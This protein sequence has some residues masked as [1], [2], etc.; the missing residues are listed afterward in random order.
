MN[1]YEVTFKDNSKKTIRA[2]NF[3]L[4]GSDAFVRFYDHAIEDR[5]DEWGNGGLVPCK[6]TKYIAA[7]PL[8][9]IKSIYLVD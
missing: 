8:A 2:E 9:D 7:L 4:Y 6:V 3:E 5:P 1:H